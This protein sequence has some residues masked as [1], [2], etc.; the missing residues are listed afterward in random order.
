M[1][2]CAKCWKANAP[3]AGGSGRI[4]R[5]L[6]GLLIVGVLRNGLTLLAVPTFDFRITT[7]GVFVLAVLAEGIRQKRRSR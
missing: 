4:E 5:T 7:G 6:V 2:G 1:I 3:L